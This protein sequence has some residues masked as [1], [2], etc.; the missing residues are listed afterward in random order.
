MKL[1]HELNECR[2]SLAPSLPSRNKIPATAAKNHAKQDLK[3]LSPRPISPTNLRHRP[4]KPSRQLHT[5][6]EQ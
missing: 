1:P 3:G 6:S 4:H 2:Q 5:Q